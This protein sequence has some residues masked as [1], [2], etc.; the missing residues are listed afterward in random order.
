MI[1][2]SGIDVIEVERVEQAL[3]RHGER[4]ERRCFHPC[5]IEA[6]RRLRRRAAFY[7]RRFA[8]KEALM[9]ALGT[10]WARGVRWA[11]IEVVQGPDGRAGL[12]LHGR[13]A[14]LARQRGAQ[15]LHLAFGGTRSLAIAVV[16]LQAGPQ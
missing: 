5:E 8:A 3:G 4:F 13:T 9:K 15:R 12:A 14:E 2:G 6:G 10:G 7:A 11:D 1:V 16:L